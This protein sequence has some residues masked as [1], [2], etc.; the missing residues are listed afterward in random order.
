M[1]CI[2]VVSERLVG[3]EELRAFNA[4]SADGIV[5]FRDGEANDAAMIGKSSLWNARPL[6]GC[7]AFG[8][9][10]LDCLFFNRIDIVGDDADPVVCVI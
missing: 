8:E 3:D 1:S 2:V 6:A 7:S 9:T 10:G 5:V 4:T